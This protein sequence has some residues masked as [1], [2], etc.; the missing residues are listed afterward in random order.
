M[1]EKQPRTPQEI[2]NDYSQICLQ[3]GDQTVKQAGFEVA[4]G[5]LLDKVK[6]L[7]VELL[8]SNA[9]YAKMQQSLEAAKAEADKK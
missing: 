9:Y 1:E 4:K 8:E 3:L 6:V 7:N 2:Q 5:Q